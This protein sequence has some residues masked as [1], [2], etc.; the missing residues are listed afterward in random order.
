[1]LVIFTPSSSRGCSAEEFLS[2]QAPRR[3]PNR[4]GELLSCQVPRCLPRS[5]YLLSCL[6]PS[7]VSEKQLRKKTFNLA[8]GFRGTQ[9]IMVGK[10]WL[11]TI[12]GSGGLHVASDMLVDLKAENLNR[13]QR[14]DGPAVM[15]S[16]GPPSSHPLPLTRASL[17]K[18]LPTGSLKH[19]FRRTSPW[20][21]FKFYFRLH[22]CAVCLYV[23]MYA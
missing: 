1:M 9:S 10:T 8:D 5:E 18:A 22:A 17:L 2:R 13:K 21:M 7:P 3:L 4:A 12:L 20:E 16:A 19:S 11:D 6:L 23:G 15:K 14:S